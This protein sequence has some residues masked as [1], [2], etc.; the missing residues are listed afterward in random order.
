M[1]VKVAAFRKT[2]ERWL[3][4]RTARCKVQEE[5]RDVKREKRP[6]MTSSQGVNEIVARSIGRSVGSVVKSAQI[7]E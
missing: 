6:A 3:D 4:S 5:V 2:E 7:E 1:F